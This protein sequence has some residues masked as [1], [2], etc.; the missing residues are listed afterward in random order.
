[1]Y[2]SVT[3]VITTFNSSNYIEKTLNSIFDQS[4]KVRKII[5]IDDNSSDFGNLETITYNF[6]KK[7]EI[8]IDL[9]SNEENLGPGYSRNIGWS[10]CQTKY[11]AFLDD[12]DYWHKDKIKIQLDIFNSLKNIDLVACKKKLKGQKIDLKKNKKNASLTKITFAKLLFKNYIPTSSVILRVDI[13]ERFLNSYYA[14]DYYLWLKILKQNKK[15][16]FLNSYLCGELNII[17]DVKLSK[18]LKEMS[19]NVHKVYNFFFT[20]NLLNNMLIIL[21]KIFCYIKMSIKSIITNL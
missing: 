15:C 12:D 9:I 3:V 16:Y 17:K 20:K 13:K 11:V 14:E 8:K 5:I 19:K 2:D 18:N 6:N 10:K 21:A 7:K 1:M 4:I